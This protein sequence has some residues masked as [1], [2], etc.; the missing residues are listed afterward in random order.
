MSNNSTCE[1]VNG[2]TICTKIIST[3][4][5]VTGISYW[6]LGSYAF[7][8]ISL[9]MAIMWIMLYLC[10]KFG[11]KERIVQLYND[12]KDKQKFMAD[13]QKIV[14]EVPLDLIRNAPE[15]M[16]VVR[17]TVSSIQHGKVPDIEQPAIMTDIKSIGD[18]LTKMKSDQ[19]VRRKAAVEILA[20]Q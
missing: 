9:L 10:S 15:I 4:C 2:V 11:L 14:N 5:D 8:V 19:E 20:K 1:I 7:N 12:R 18:E 16:D 13:L 3:S 6:S 17:S